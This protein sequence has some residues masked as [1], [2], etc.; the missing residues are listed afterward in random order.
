MVQN[1][2]NGEA[3]DGLVRE[4]DRW[5]KTG[6][7]ARFWWRDDDATRPGPR[8]QRLLT[9]ARGVP[10]SLAVIPADVSGLLPD[11]LT[12]F[13]EVTV[14]QHGYAH[15]NHAPADRKKSEFPD[16]RE[17]TEA[18]DQVAA[19]CARL[20]EHFGARFRPVLV[21][22][23][24]RIADC[25]PPHL[26]EIGLQGLS[27]Y[28]RKARPEHG[29]LWV[30]THCDIIAWRSTRGFIG[31]NDVLRLMTDHL[32]ARREGDAADEPTGLMTHHI[33]HDDECWQF[34]ESF[35]TVLAGHPAAA[36]CDPFEA[37]STV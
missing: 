6:R 5:R 18:L 33:V 22:P 19:G 25:Y 16:T 34:L 30:D 20:A 2:L 17:E 29:L 31:A 32:S 8:L 11:F 4:L 27:T 13:P 1:D 10:L 35:V 26:P 28:R 37:L 3:W 7:T 15:R 24:N 14:L 23:W 36:W 12:A 21:P 9:T